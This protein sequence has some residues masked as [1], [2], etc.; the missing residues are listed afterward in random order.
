M[1]VRACVRKREAKRLVAG[2]A[3]RRRGKKN[4]DPF[5]PLR[6]ELHSNSRRT[7]SSAHQRPGVPTYERH[8]G[9]NFNTPA[10]QIL[11]I[12]Q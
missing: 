9:H 2:G 7:R 12:P 6:P 3:G 4:V 10:Y 11:I 1:S 5:F 8:L